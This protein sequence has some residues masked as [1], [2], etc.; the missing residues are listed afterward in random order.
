MPGRLE[1]KPTYLAGLKGRPRKTERRDLKVRVY[2]DVAV[3]TG[4]M[5]NTPASGEPVEAMV[6]QT[7]VKNGSRWQVVAFQASRLQR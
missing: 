6:T 2:G 4:L 7:W 3:M 5:I 1:D